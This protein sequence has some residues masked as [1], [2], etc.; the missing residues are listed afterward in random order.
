[1]NGTFTVCAA[2]AVGDGSDIG[3]L[4]MG[5]YLVTHRLLREYLKLFVS[6]G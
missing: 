5:D 2:E 1:M 4:N 6:D 3:V